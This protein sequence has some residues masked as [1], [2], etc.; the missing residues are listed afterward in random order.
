MNGALAQVSR[1][2]L[3]R[4]MVQGTTLLLVILVP[5]LGLFRIDPRAGAL[6]VL[7]RQ[8]WF[9]DFFLIAGL[10]IILLSLLVMLYSTAGTVFCGWVCPQNIFSE[11]ANYMTHRLLGKRAEVSLDGQ[12][13]VIAP[14]KNRVWNWV[15]LGLS[16][17]LASMFLGVIPLFY[18]YDPSTILAF[19]LW[20]SDPALASSLHWIYAVFVLIILVDIAV[21][22]HFWCRFACVYRV[23]QHS[24][25][26]RET[27]HVRYDASRA[28]ACEKCNYC[29]TSCFIEIDPRKTDVYD[30]CINCG[31]CIDACN[32]LQAKKG[33]PGLLSFEFGEHKTKRE[34]RIHFR[35]NAVGLT[36]RTSWM[37]VVMILGLS[38]FAWGL[39]TWE[40]L[41]LAAY[42]AEVQDAANDLDYRIEIANKRY[43]P[44]TVELSVQGLKPGEYHLSRTQLTIPAAGRLSAIL[45]I[46]PALPHGVHS[47]RILARAVQENWTDQFAIQHFSEAPKGR[48]P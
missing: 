34:A 23:W 47:F 14:A 12:A 5:A 43:R 3:H 20:R 10:W 16:F 41:H 38:F 19:L 42:R 4:R 25:R 21:I 18:F 15:L 33:N 28:S 9:A 30:S 24:F 11:W 6:V 26:T 29:V 36:S 45:S 48:T 46:S 13:P 2:H 37:A 27:L 22:R 40:P 35:N 32:R 39:W 31:E 44:E 8:I 1:F 7:D 17:V